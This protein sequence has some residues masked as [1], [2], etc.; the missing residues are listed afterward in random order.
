MSISLWCAMASEKV[1]VK[2]IGL[3]PHAGEYGMIEVVDGRVDVMAPLGIGAHDMVLV[4][5]DACV[6]GEEGCYAPLRNLN[7]LWTRTTAQKAKR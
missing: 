4:S 1:R 5:L 2:I 3:H 7:I 6:H